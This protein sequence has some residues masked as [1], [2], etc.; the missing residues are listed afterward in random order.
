M[1]IP[2][3]ETIVPHEKADIASKKARYFY[4]MST[5]SYVGFSVRDVGEE[6]MFG[7][8]GRQGVALDCRPDLGFGVVVEVVKDGSPR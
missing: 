5:G 6:S 3:D 1:Y 8:Y 4:R 2:Y 7:G